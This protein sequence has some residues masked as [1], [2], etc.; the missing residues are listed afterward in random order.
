MRIYAPFLLFFAVLSAV[1]LCCVPMPSI[2]Q[3]GRYDAFEMYFD[4]SSPSPGE[5]VTI[6]LRSGSASSFNIRSVR[7][8]VNGDEQPDWADKLSVS[9]INESF[10]KQITANVVFFDMHGQRQFVQVVGWMRP[11]IFDLFWEADA[12]VTP[13]YRGHKLAGPQVPIRLSAKIQYLDG[14]GAVYTE[15]D[16]SFR[17]EVES[18]FHADQGPGVSS[19][20]FEEGGTYMNNFVSVRAEAFLINNPNIGFEQ[21]TLIPITKPRLLVYPY[22]LLRGLSDERT[23]P[24][25]FSPRGDSFTASVYPFYFGRD[26]LEK[27][28]VQYN[29]FVNNSRTPSRSGRRIDISTEGGGVSVPIQ[30]TANN[31]NANLQ[32]LSY[33]FTLDL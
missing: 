8:F 14:W 21:S 33:T 13:R 26:D 19:I 6:S 3:Q 20:V 7:W 5:S 16:F 28:A 17:W 32:T 2:A 25:R 24:L 15:K 29:W 23:L 31:D 4:D 22:T 18:T 9:E 30:I 27:S 11:V 12:V 1:W 10:P